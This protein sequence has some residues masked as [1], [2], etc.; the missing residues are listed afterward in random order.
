V[1]FLA[2]PWIR[3]GKLASRVRRAPPVDRE[4]LLRELVP[5]RSFLEVGGM[6][7]IH[8]KFSF[9]AEESGATK[10][11][12]VDIGRPPE[13]V[14]E[15]ERRDSKIEFI[16]GDLNNPATQAAIEPHEVVW[17]TGVLYHVPNPL[18]SLWNLRNMT[19]DVLV[20]GSAMLPEV[21]GLPGAC[22]FYPALGERERK[23]YAPAT[24][25]SASSAA[26]GVTTPYEPAAGYANWF[27]GITPSALR[28][29]FKAT[30]LREE[31]FLGDSFHRTIVARRVDI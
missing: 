29:M 24:T 16:K 15:H 30:G 25:G 26:V 31:R 3:A 17:C 27:W 12:S 19:S 7:R 18:A 11:T 28:G 14:A 6:W 13:F 1:A 22:I 23:D 9:L 5:G 10:V 4:S 21:P 20:L 8:G 2:K